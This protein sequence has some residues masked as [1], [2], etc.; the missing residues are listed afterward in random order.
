MELHTTRF[1]QLDSETL[2]QLLR[3]RVDVFVV[4]Q[5]CAYP[6]LDGRDIEPDAMHLWLTDG[7]DKAPLGYLRVLTEPTGAARIGRVAVAPAARGAG[8]ARRLM[9]AALTQV[10]ERP[11][12]LDA[13]ANL[14]EFYR[15]LG[16]EVTGP[17]YLEDG[18]P[19]VPM[20]RTGKSAVDEE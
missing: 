11:C 4:E 14:V 20:W 18:I 1:E 6:E 3:L 19:H 12:V 17:E 7:D 8:I 10:G 2:Y 15:S 5:H 9:T 13:Q 16:F